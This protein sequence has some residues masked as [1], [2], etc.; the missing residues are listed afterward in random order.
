MAHVR[1]PRAILAAVAL[2]TAVAATAMGLFYWA[3]IEHLRGEL[4]QNRKATKRLFEVVQDFSQNFV[5]IQ[6]SFNE[7]CSLLFQLV[8]A[9]PT[10]LDA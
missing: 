3:Q 5:E 1:E 7:L 10:L 9:N 4:F 6:N 2:S 8:L